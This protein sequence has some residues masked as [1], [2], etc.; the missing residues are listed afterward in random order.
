MFLTARY[1]LAVISFDA[2]SG[3]VVTRAH[4]NVKVGEQRNIK[5][6]SV[7]G[8]EWSCD[9]VKSGVWKKQKKTTAGAN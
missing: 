3:E 2:D 4:G 7:L 6:G 9:K 5:H 1:N 8:W